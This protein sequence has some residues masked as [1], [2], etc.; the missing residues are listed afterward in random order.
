MSRMRRDRGGIAEGP[1]P[2]CQRAGRR[3]LTGML[4]VWAS[5]VVQVAAAQPNSQP[6]TSPPAA[7]TPA[8]SVQARPAPSVQGAAPIEEYCKSGDNADTAVCKAFA[9]GKCVSG[10]TVA[11]CQE[12][13]GSI[14]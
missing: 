9:S 12:R 7:G 10:L 11:L 4:L 6:P 2:V 1:Q 8:P 14:W 5:V 13:L 3:R